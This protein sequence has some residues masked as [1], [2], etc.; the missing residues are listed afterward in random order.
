L[1][2]ASGALK[3]SIPRINAGAPTRRFRQPWWEPSASADCPAKP[4]LTST[5]C[6]SDWDG[7]A[8]ALKRRIDVDPCSGALKRSIPRINAGG[9]TDLRFRQLSWEPSAS[10]EGSNASALRE[11]IRKGSCALAPA[12]PG[13]KTLSSFSRMAARLKSCPAR[14]LSFPKA[15]KAALLINSTGECSAVEVVSRRRGE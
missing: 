10:A 4:G 7:K 11:R 6:A 5:Q 9:P 13:A 2:L 14:K 15:V 8:P 3:R 1:T 12:I